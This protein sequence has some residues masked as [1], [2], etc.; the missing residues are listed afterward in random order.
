MLTQFKTNH[1]KSRF[2]K[3]KAIFRAMRFA[4]RNPRHVQIAV[5][6]EDGEFTMHSNYSGLNEHGHMR[7][8][9]E[10]GEEVEMMQVTEKKFKNMMN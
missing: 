4:Y 3:V 2:W 6:L 9:K 1:W 8:L 7:V 10:V 5:S